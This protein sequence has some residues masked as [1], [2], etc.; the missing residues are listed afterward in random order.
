MLFCPRKQSLVHQKYLPRGNN[1]QPK[2][3]MSTLN[4]YLNDSVKKKNQFYYKFVVI[5]NFG[6]SQV[7]GVV[8]NPPANAGDLRD[9]GL[10]LGSGRS[11]G[12]EHGNP[13]QYSCLGNPM[14]RGA[15]RATGHSVAKRWT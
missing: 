11:P 7:A 3:L 4:V 2:I 10:I 13:R 14:D 1:I 12:R 6:V 8:K 9:A 5:S 15:W